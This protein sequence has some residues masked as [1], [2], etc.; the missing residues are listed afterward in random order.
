[1]VSL[2][3]ALMGKPI[4]YSNIENLVL[5]VRSHAT[6]CAIVKYRGLMDS[7]FSL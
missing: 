2:Y 6:G 7:Q 5:W 4:I 3:G 1:M